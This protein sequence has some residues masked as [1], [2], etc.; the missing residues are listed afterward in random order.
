M[1]TLGVSR[2]FVTVLLTLFTMAAVIAVGLYADSIYLWHAHANHMATAEQFKRDFDERLPIGASV[3]DVERYLMTRHV[4]IVRPVPGPT[5]GPDYRVTVTR[6]RSPYWF[7][8]RGDV[9]LIV[10]FSAERQ[11]MKTEATWWSF[12]CL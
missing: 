9:G 3:A 1:K 12:D 5:D 6:E 2:R 8:G 10:H 11:V 7:C 4:E